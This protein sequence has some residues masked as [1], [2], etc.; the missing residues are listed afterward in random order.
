ML[1][2]PLGANREGSEWGRN[3]AA[4]MVVRALTDQNTSVIPAV[5]PARDGLRVRNFESTHVPLCL[6]AG[7]GP[8]FFECLVFVNGKAAWYNCIRVNF[9]DYL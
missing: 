3:V 8:A 4:N 2:H 6:T 7:P 9:V 5:I 1:S